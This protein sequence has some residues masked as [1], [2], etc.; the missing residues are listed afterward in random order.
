[1]AVATDGRARAKVRIAMCIPKRRKGRV[2]LTARE[3]M[4]G[5]FGFRGQSF[6]DW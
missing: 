6:S 4:S 3:G 5:I 1:M 2:V